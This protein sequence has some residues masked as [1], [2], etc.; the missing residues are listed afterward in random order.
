MTGRALIRTADAIDLQALDDVVRRAYAE[1]ED[2]FPDWTPALRGT[3]LMTQLARDAEILAATLD[4]TV[5]GGVGYVAPGRARAPCFPAEWAV[6]RLMAVDPACRG[7]G[8]AGALVQECAR[9]A[10]EDRAPVLGLYTSPA[11]K[12]AVAMYRRAGFQYRETLAPVM[13]MPCHLYAL[14]LKA[15]LP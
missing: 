4:D 14:T 10:R 2:D 9:R 6:L 11:M 8:V 7:R 5:S 1:Y 15:P 12:I 13:G 3:G